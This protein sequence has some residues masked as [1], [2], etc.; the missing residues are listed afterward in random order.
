MK[1]IVISAKRIKTELVTLLV[2]FLIGI[3]A[4]IG[5]V[6]YYQ[7]AASELITSIPYVLV[8]TFVIYS[9]WSLFRLIRGLISIIWKKKKDFGT[10]Q[11]L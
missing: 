10:Q 1:D 8:F 2:C 5:A 3:V 11:P 4:N 9:L 7:S 6:L